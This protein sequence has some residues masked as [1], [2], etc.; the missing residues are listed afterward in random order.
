MSSKPV[1]QLS[2]NLSGRADWYSTFGF[3]VNLQAIVGLPVED[4][5]GDALDT[6]RGLVRPRNRDVVEGL[7]EPVVHV[8]TFPLRRH[9]RL[10]RERI[11]L[12][13]Y[14]QQFLRKHSKNCLSK[15]FSV[16][17]FRETIGEFIAARN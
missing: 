1:E 17:Q 3:A 13:P 11:T 9:E 6:V 12:H 5:I 8:K 2:F 16:H 7:P 15:P 4:P 10:D 14:P